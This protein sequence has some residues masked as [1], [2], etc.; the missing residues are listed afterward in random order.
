[1]ITKVVLFLN[2]IK[3]D[4]KD[5]RLEILSIFLTQDIKELHPQWS[6]DI[7]MPQMETFT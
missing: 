3:K 6:F 5:P 4:N 1:M 7:F 2:F